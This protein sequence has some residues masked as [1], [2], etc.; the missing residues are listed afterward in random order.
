MATED[1][2]TQ[3]VALETRVWEALRTGDV[4]SATELFD[5]HFLGV[6]PTGFSSRSEHVD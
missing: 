1:R 4:E 3:F 6:Y 2:L 5:D